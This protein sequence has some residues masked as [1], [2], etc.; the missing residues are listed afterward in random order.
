LISR[1]RRD[2]PI[3]SV[4]AWPIAKWRFFAVQING[5]LHVGCVCCFGMQTY[6]GV[7]VH[8]YLVLGDHRMSIFSSCRE[9]RYFVFGFV[10]CFGMRGCLPR[11][12]SP[13]IFV[14][15]A[16]TEC[17]FFPAGSLFVA[18]ACVC[19]FKTQQLISQHQ[20]PPK[21]V[22]CPAGRVCVLPLVLVHLYLQ[23]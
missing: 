16:I 3:I 18:L 20:P 9:L 6:H 11:R 4:C 19:A 5:E 13:Y 12:D 15:L 22:Q 2:G 10:R 21:F 17:R 8:I 23:L 1:L 7:I 14:C